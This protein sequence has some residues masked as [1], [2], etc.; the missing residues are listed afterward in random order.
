M[1]AH[2]ARDGRRRRVLNEEVLTA[3]S[4]SVAAYE[5]AAEPEAPR[6]GEQASVENHPQVTDFVPRRKWAVM[7]TLLAGL[8][9]AGGAQALVR[10][11]E[12]LAASVP[13]LSVSTIGKV[14]GGVT[15]WCSAVALLGCYLLARLIYSLRRHRVDDYAGRYRAWRWVGWSA[16]LA[17]VTAV[18]PIEEAVASVGTGATG[19]TL[20]ASGAEWWIAPM[21]LVGG[22]IAVRL[23][24]E[25]GESRS[26]VAMLLAALGC[27][28]A[29][30]VGSLGWRPELLGAWGG[31]A[32]AA[33]PLAG[34]T[35]ALAG[36]MIFGRYVVLD[37]QG[38]IDH[39][40][41]AV[42]PA[43]PKGA[44]QPSEKTAKKVE[45]APTV[46]IAAVSA[47]DAGAAT[48]EVPSVDEEAEWWD[49]HE[50]EQGGR[51]LSKAQRKQLRKQQ[52]RAA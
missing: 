23:L 4:L 35:F 49:E 52:R 50:A 18:V 51:K 40:P 31:L 28:G 5:Q 25:V 33:A 10:N 39:K 42:K 38:L 22:W 26:S 13:G 3:S 47:G 44:K 15:T 8:G 12:V 17:S 9:V 24:L 6:Y 14:A 11:A 20:T 41:R 21:A 45:A 32:F 48:A 30:A 16:L 37:V 27:Y 1:A 29:A 36:L 43:K 34:H 2:M 19:W 46:K 7:A